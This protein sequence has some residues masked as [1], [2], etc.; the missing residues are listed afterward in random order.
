MG[1]RKRSLL[2]LAGGILISAGVI[3]GAMRAVPAAI[4]LECGHVT[5]GSMEPSI[6]AGDLVYFRKSDP[7]DIDAGDI[8]VFGNG[9]GGDTVHRVARNDR[10]SASIITKGDANASEDPDPVPYGRVKGVFVWSLDRRIAVFP[11][12]GHGLAAAMCMCGSGCMLLVM[13]RTYRNPDEGR[14]TS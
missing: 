2:A 12:Y 11:S 5:S 13:S 8:I 7:A 9:H 10:S 1:I 4:G 14:E 3:I 6:N